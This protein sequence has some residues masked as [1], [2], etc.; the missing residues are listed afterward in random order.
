MPN[1]PTAVLQ[2]SSLTRKQLL[3]YIATDL[4]PSIKEDTMTALTDALGRLQ[5]EVSQ[6]LQQTADALAGL[7]TAV[8]NLAVSE[9]EKAALQ[10][11][12]DEATAANEQAVAG[13][14]A[15]SDALASDDPSEPDPEPEP[16]PEPVDPNA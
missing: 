2:L 7:Q 3:W 13:I 5:T 16:E 10:A 8:D 15:Q 9:Q 11:A 14:N 4:I 12:L 6:Q 1:Q